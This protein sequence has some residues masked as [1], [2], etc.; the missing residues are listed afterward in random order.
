MVGKRPQVKYLK[1]FG[2]TV[3]IHNKTRKSKFNEKSW[4]GILVGYEPNGYKVWDVETEKFVTVRDV[5]VDETTY[6]KSRPVMGLDGINFEN[7]YNETD[8]SDI[9]SKSVEKSHKSDNDKSDMLKRYKSDNNRSDIVNPSVKVRDET[10]KS[11]AETDIRN[12]SSSQD[13]KS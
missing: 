13:K 7:A 10:N 5:I 12:I 3:Y 1:I 4:K 9:R 8:A 2:S 11:V 6:L